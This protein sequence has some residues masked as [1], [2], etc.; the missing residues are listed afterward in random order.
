MKH[1]LLALGLVPA[2]AFAAP[3]TWNVD[4]AHTQTNFTVRHLAI[5]NVRG[6]FQSTTGVV[7]LDEKDPARSSVEATIDAN[8]INTREDKRDAHLRSPDFLDVAKYPSITFRSTKVR[9]AGKV[10]EVTGDLTMHGV[11]RPVV[12][13]V[14]DLTPAMKDP[15]GMD[16]R[17]VRATTKLS[18]K[19]FGLEWNKMVEATPV[20]GDEIRIEIDAE[21]VKQPAE[22]AK[23]AEA[24]P[25]PAPAKVD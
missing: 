13:E 14:S 2:L 6:E 15:M 12:L 11:T 23:E 16:R 4:P 10:Y 22:G 8:T 17:G 1:V 3:T 9:K 7:K 21:L 25:Q 5:S 20:V 18:R 24:T 19:A